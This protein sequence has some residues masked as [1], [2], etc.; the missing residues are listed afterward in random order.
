MGEAMSKT[1]SELAAQV[2]ALRLTHGSNAAVG[3]AMEREGL[4]HIRHQDRAAL[5]R[6]A[7]FPADLLDRLHSVAPRK[8]P[9]HFL[10]YAR[11][12]FPEFKVAFTLAMSKTE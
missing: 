11:R 7:G 8:A 2:A 4:G 12:V 6:L 5:I 9:Q 1:I 10:P 3:A